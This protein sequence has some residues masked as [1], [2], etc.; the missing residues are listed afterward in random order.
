MHYLKG[1]RHYLRLL[2]LLVIL[3]GTEGLLAQEKPLPI[4]SVN[5]LLSGTASIYE[6]YFTELKAVLPAHYRL[7][8]FNVESWVPEQKSNPSLFRWDL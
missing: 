7:K 1:L 3:T 2:F 4:E 6:D 5:V 8:K